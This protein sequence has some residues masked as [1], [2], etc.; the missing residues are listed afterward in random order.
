LRGRGAPADSRI[1]PIRQKIIR[2]D[3]IRE[4]S[5]DKPAGGPVKGRYLIKSPERDGPP[6]RRRLSRQELPVAAGSPPPPAAGTR[7]PISPTL[8]AGSLKPPAAPAPERGPTRREAG[9]PFTPPPAR[10]GQDKFL[11]P[12]ARAGGPEGSFLTHPFGT[13][14][15]FQTHLKL[16]GHSHPIR[17]RPGRRSRRPG[18]STPP[19]PF[20]PDTSLRKPSSFPSVQTD[21]A[22][23]PARSPRLSLPPV[24]PA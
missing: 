5:L 17:H 20:P 8:K 6:G 23:P 19:F 16:F 2:Q 18:V 11:A 10:T 12:P 14:S 3:K 13:V 22:F 21:P 15:Q 9:P 1:A 7:L 4:I 24:P